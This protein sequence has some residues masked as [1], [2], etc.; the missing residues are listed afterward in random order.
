MEDEKKSTYTPSVK[1][2]ILKHRAS[3]LEEYNELCRNYYHKMKTDEEWIAKWR[4]KCRKANE[5][6]R[7]KK[8]EGQEPKKRGRPRKDLGEKID[9]ENTII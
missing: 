5:K 4:E 6:Y 7:E 1:K 2:A 8:R 9:C 3:H